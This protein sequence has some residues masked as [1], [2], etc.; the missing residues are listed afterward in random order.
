MVC[1]ARW[2]TEEGVDSR[3]LAAMRTTRSP[4]LWIFSVSWS[5]ATLD[6]A[7]TST[8][9][10]FCLARWYT[11]EAEVTVLPVPGWMSSVSW[12]QLNK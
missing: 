5:T 9:P 3:L 4:D 11:M 6:G 12:W 7:H 10:T 1:S 2:S 8:W